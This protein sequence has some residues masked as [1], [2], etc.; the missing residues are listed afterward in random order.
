MIQP[1]LILGVFLAALA[2]DAPP[3][4]AQAV[5]PGLDSVIERVE[6]RDIPLRDLLHILSAESGVN[7]VASQE[8]GGK[9]ISLYLQNATVRQAVEAVAK[10][11]DLWYREDD[12]GGVVRMMSTKEFERDLMLFRDE[13]TNVFTLLYP[14]ALDVGT[15]IRSLFGDRVR[16]SMDRQSMFDEMIEMQQRF[17]RF[18]LLQQRAQGL[19]RGGSNVNNNNGYNSGYNNSFGGQSGGQFGGLNS[20][21][22][23][24]NSGYSAANQPADDIVGN[25]NGTNAGKAPLTPEKIQALQQQPGGA[26]EYAAVDQA[27]GRQASI[28]VTVVRKNNMVAVRTS[29]SAAMEQIQQL[30]RAL[31]VPT[32]QVLLEVKILSISLGDDFNSVF[33]FDY[34]RGNNTLQLNQAST[35]GAP[36]DARNLIYKFVNNE[37]LTRLQLLQ[38]KRRVTTL[39]TPIL[40]V[41]NN[42][43]ARVFVGEERPVVRNVVTQS[44]QNQN[45]T[46]TTG[47]TQAE[48]VQVGTTL[49]ITPNVN[50]DRTVTLRIVQENAQIKKG[51]AI[52]PVVVNN[53][54]INQPVDVVQSRNV[55]GT[56]IAKDGLALALGGL[57][58][59]NISDTQA[60][61]PLLMDLPFVGFLFRREE[62]T[63]S[64]SELV[65]YVRPF[66]L[67]TA[68]EGV[69]LSA[70]ISE[71]LQIHPEKGAV[72]GDN[73]GTFRANEVPRGRLGA[74]PLKE[75]L[76][77]QSGLPGNKDK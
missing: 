42:E 54:V 11:Y 35:S 65:V 75:M 74:D 29:D 53:D 50:A 43:V 6:F 36:T 13:K 52:I 76:Q 9:E 4:A 41:A 47:T 22:N 46:L 2:Q 69:R 77:Y 25:S 7:F 31:D 58:E 45:T 63:R 39:A 19:S 8:A 12:K 71:R 57:I 49:L 26:L 44:S 1:F 59:E 68:N 30:V 37:I 40:L 15:A 55:T 21:N 32:P 5:T 70:E 51:D 38:Q 66:V 16:L 62:K 64:R 20:F 18:D 33:G 27:T 10:S 23:F 14:N 61:I 72:P 67:L 28:F 56:V 48:L 73:L 34:N 3:P 17:Q 60:G 24:N